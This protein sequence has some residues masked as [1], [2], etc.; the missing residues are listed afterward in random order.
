VLTGLWWGNQKERDHLNDLNEE[1]NIKMYIQVLV[2]VM[3]WIDMA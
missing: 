1:D 3:G 2:W